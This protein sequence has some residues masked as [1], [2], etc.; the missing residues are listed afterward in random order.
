[1]ARITIFDTTLRDGEQSPGASMTA[2]E[3]L[4][5]AHEL[6]ELGVDV[7][8]AGFAAASPDE[9]AAIAAIGREVTGPRITALA[10]AHSG[11]IEA[12]ARAVESAAKPG[13]H[14]FIAT[15]DIH[16]EK[17]L[18]IGMEECLERAGEA[19]RLARTFVEDVEFSAEDATRS[20]PDFLT[21]VVQVAVEAGA[22]TIN[23]PDTVGYA[24]PDEIREMIR[25]LLDRV[26]DLGQCVISTHCHDDLGLAVANSLAAVE[27]GARQVECTMNGIGERAGNAALEEVVMALRV[28]ENGLGHETGIQHDRLYRTSRLLSYLTGIQPQ[29]NKAIVGRNAF[30]HEAG[31]HQHGMLND[32][33]TY[34]I[35]TPEMVGVSRSTLVMGK[36]SGRHGLEA[37]LAELGYK[38]SPEELVAVAERFQE[39]ADRKKDIL[40]EDLIS[41][42]HHRVMEDVP[43]IHRIVELDVQC[44]GDVSAASVTVMSEGGFPRFAQAEGDG[45]IAAAF[46]AAE[47]LHD[48]KIVLDEFEIHAATPGRDALGEVTIRAHADGQ[49]FTGRGGATDVVLAATQAYFHVVN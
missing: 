46:A 41:I 1:M 12:A 45:P 4:R 29:P 48:F 21:R 15:S 10:R 37:R 49:T 47:Q 13:I 23:L 39:L 40:D 14:V 16:L 30:S 20:D 34:E 8:E 24:L 33:R 25:G 5:M 32:P 43:E 26:P 31:I 42:L 7:L 6:G 17:K 9:V 3:K 38:L 36:H 2:A 44:G 35:M 18:G 11:D 22:K 27:A 19:V 28:R